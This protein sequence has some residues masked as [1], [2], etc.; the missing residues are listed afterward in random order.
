MI[1]E[2]LEKTPG[3]FFTIV[4]LA[5]VVGTMVDSMSNAKEE[6]GKPDPKA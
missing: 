3:L 6:Q 1:M 4:L 2:I 5:F